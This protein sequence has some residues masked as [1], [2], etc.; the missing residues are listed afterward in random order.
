MDQS[1]R[2]ASLLLEP[3]KK[4]GAGSNI[5]WIPY[6]FISP[7]LLGFLIFYIGPM[8]TSLYL[9]FTN[10][11][12]L[13]SPK[14]VGFDNFTKMFTRDQRFVTSLIVTFK[15][16]LI[17]VPLKLFFALILAMIFNKGIRGTSFYRTVY[18]VPS[19]VGGSVAVAIIWKKLFGLDGAINQVLGYV[20]IGAKHWIS[21]P[22]TALS[23][24]IVL[25]VWQFGS[26]MLIFLA[27]L[28]QIPAE[29]YEASSIDGANRFQS[30]FNI[31]IPMLSP[32]I[33]FNLIMQVIHA[34]M[35]F[36]QS[37]LITKGGPADSTLFYAVYL[38]ERGFTYFEMG[39]AS[40]LAWILLIIVALF[41]LLIFKTSTSW[42]H[43][44][45]DGKD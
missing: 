31:T 20:G 43:Y 4:G 29:M 12:L 10:Y 7:W 15:F 27:G 41:T 32:I 9:S 16:V 35:A 44:E 26:P 19:I 39:Y 30:F 23:T 14:W 34:F 36:T 24:L 45:N 38:Y 42:V 17:S 2:Q 8:F 11:D 21:D 28:K 22:D 18:Y 37:F 33:F 40:A 3:S 25:V 6:L 1:N 13:S 5:N